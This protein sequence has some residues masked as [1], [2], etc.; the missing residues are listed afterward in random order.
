MDDRADYDELAWD[1]NDEQKAKLEN[2]FLCFSTV[3]TLAAVVGAAFAEEAR[4]LRPVHIGGW[5]IVFVMELIAS[6]SRV[7]IRVPRPHTARFAREKTCM[8]TATMKF[9]SQ[10]T[11][12]SMPTLFSHGQHADLGYY[13]ILDFVENTGLLSHALAKPNEDGEEDDVAVLNMAMPSCQLEAYFYD[14]AV[15]VRHLFQPSF[16]A[17]G[18]LNQI[19]DGLVK[20]GGRPL[21]QNMYNMVYLANIPPSVLPAED[22]IHHTAD[23]WYTALAEMHMLQLTFQQNDLV[24]DEDDCRNKYIA[25]YLFLKLARAGKLSTFGFTDDTW[26]AQSRSSMRGCCTAPSNT[27]SFRIWCDD[28]RPANILLHKGRDSGSTVI[29]WE[30]TYVA[31]TQFTLDPPWWLLLDV[32]EMW[33]SGIEDWAEQYGRCLDVW[34][35]AMRRAEQSSDETP[36]GFLLSA[37]MQE[38]WTTGRF[39]LNYAARK[40]WAFDSIFWRYLDERFFGRRAHELVNQEPLWRRRIG[41]L[42]RAEKIAME[43]F[44]DRKMKESQDKHLRTWGEQEAQKRKAEVLLTHDQGPLR[45]CYAILIRFVGHF[46]T[47][48]SHLRGN[49]Q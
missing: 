38:S 5:N 36:N 4:W 25:R 40:S 18:S 7:V 34:L 15:Q 16:A 1:R 24:K 22:K 45:Q 11:K 20:V 48:V 43:A 9:L 32:P 27:G 2:P 44:V 35:Q 3:E 30:F 47:V 19:Q 13:I 23:D 26:S 28:F 31:P 12:A 42:S 10:H 49:T 41:L 39:W 17:I 29:D 21:T 33:H 14:V 46:Q 6:N 8:E 37:Y